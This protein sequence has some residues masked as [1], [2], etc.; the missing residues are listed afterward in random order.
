MFN[1]SLNIL[2]VRMISVF[3]IGTKTLSDIQG[4]VVGIM[5][6]AILVRIFGTYVGVTGGP[7]SAVQRIAII[8]GLLSHLAKSLNAAWQFHVAKSLNGG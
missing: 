4:H 6:M 7:Y 2:Q 8:L 5:K 1:R 3:I